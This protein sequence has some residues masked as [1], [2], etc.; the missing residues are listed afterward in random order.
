VD[1]EL[2][3]VRRMKTTRAGIVEPCLAKPFERPLDE[4]HGNSQALGK[5]SKSPGAR[6]SQEP[7]SDVEVA[8]VHGKYNGSMYRYMI[9]SLKGPFPDVPR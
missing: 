9:L 6:G 1:G 3:E 5:R 8:L 2:L 7:R 4:R